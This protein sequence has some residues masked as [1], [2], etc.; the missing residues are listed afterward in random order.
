MVELG[1]N[2]R[3][4][5]FQCA[6]GQ[7]QLRKLPAWI[8]RRQELACLYDGA[9]ARV[10]GSRRP[11]VRPGVSHAYHLY[12]VR[13]AEHDRVYGSLRDAGIGANVHYIPVHL[14]PFYRERFGTGHGLCP[15]AEA[16][17]AEILSLPLFP[18][19]RRHAAAAVVDGAGDGENRPE[20][21]GQDEDG[22]CRG[23]RVGAVRAGLV[24]EQ[25]RVER[26]QQCQS[27]VDGQ[28]G[29]QQAT[30]VRPVGRPA[31]SQEAVRQGAGQ[32]CCRGYRRGRQRRIRPARR[33]SGGSLAHVTCDCRSQRPPL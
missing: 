30:A 12:V 13:V 7:S 19:R 15:V 6:L 17:Y 20:R 33:R 21:A 24:H 26:A 27:R 18:Q 10:P 29:R 25:Q 1:F 4:T 22:R 2:Y 16:A 14:H 28:D 32:R 9:L 23:G 8:E 31:R 5:D 11:A 3:L